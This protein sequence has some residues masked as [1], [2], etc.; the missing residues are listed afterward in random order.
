MRPT[1]ALH[2][3]FARSLGEP[4]GLAGAGRRPIRTR[5]RLPCT[6]I[7]AESM[8]MSRVPRFPAM[9]HRALPLVRPRA[10]PGRRDWESGIIADSRG[11][12]GC[13]RGAMPGA[14]PTDILQGRQHRCAAGSAGS[15]RA[16]L[17]SHDL[18][19]QGLSRNTAL[20]HSSST[21]A[22]RVCARLAVWRIDQCDG[23]VAGSGWCRGACLRREGVYLQYPL[24]DMLR[25]VSLESHRNQAIVIGEDLGHGWWWFWGGGG[26]V[27]CGDFY[28]WC[29]LGENK[30]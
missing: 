21:F 20:R 13:R 10:R 16:G 15:A 19:A 9:A 22:F 25:I 7:C 2:A 14:V 5:R 12:D 23:A 3:H 17:G 4:R 27:V 11:R 18:F 24:D 30:V 6:G 8:H 1:E 29:L 28:P 26:G